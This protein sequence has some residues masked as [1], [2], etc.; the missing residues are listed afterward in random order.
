MRTALPL[1]TSFMLAGAVFAGASDKYICVGDGLNPRVVR[2][3]K[4]FAVEETCEVK[5]P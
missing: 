2:V 4:K 1:L 3:D 5:G